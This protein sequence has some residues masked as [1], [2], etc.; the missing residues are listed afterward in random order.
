MSTH[1]QVNR[2][3]GIFLKK[4]LFTIGQVCKVC[5][6]SR[7]TILRLEDRGLIFPAYYDEKSGYRYYDNNNIAK[8]LQIK[9]FQ[10]MGLQYNDIAEYYNSNGNSA[11]IVGK[12]EKRMLVLKRALDEMKLRIEDKNHL[13][14][15]IIDL[16][17][18][19]CYVREYTGTSISDRY[20]NMYD[21]YHEA[22]E[23]GYRPL[24]AE[25]LFVINKRDDF[26]DGEFRYK[27]KIN[28]I[29]C[30]PLEPDCASEETTKIPGGKALSVLHYGNYAAINE[31][32]NFLGKKVLELNL[33]P[34]GY[35]RTLG[36]V[37]PYTGREIKPDK[38]VTR[39]VLPVEM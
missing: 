2:I 22:C 38:Y 20:R 8:L 39:L 12:L 5:T 32:Y 9:A 15:E 25:P 18:Y 11:A 7:S 35:P 13:T 3:E 19:I 27:E 31:A 28:Y 14:A 6:V 30:L 29:C 16:P 21:L 33:K 37:A 24:A 34:A 26:Y 1:E 17:D 4:D 23:K 10:E 36:L